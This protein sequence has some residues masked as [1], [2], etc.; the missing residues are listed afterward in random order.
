M[1]KRKKKSKSKSP[2]GP[3]E[4]DKK[5]NFRV[6]TAKNKVN[7]VIG[8]HKKMT[9]KQ[10]AVKEK[11]FTRRMEV[12][13]LITEYGYNNR[14]LSKMMDVGVDTIQNDREWLEELWLKEAVTDV[15]TAKQ[16]LVQRKTWVMQEARQAWEKSNQRSRVVKEK[17]KDVQSGQGSKKGNSKEKEK[18]ETIKDE[19]GNPKYLEIYDKAAEDIAHLQGVKKDHIKNEINIVMP[20]LPAE[21]AEYGVPV[22]EGKKSKKQVEDAEDA[23]YVDIDN[24]DEEDIRK[25]QGKKE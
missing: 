4:I 1:A 2:E 19:L 5:D 11:M 22:E 21:F 16:Q 20:S 10:R 8:R 15:E 25:N 7:E 14:T 12:A 17:E 13:K 18:A 3:M 6:K 9:P 24:L 23:Y